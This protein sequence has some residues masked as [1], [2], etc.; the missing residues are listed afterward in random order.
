MLQELAS[1]LAIPG[2]PDWMGLVVLAALALAGLAYLLMPFSVF[3]VKGR[4]DAIE[5]RGLEIDGLDILREDDVLVLQSKQAQRSVLADH[6][7]SASPEHHGQRVVEGQRLMQTVSDPFL[8]WTTNAHHEHIYWRH[9]R[10]WKGAVQLERLDPHALD[11][12]GRLCAITLAKAHARSGDRAAITDCM[13]EG[14]R[15]DEA[16]A[17]FAMAYADQSAADDQRLHAAIARGRLAIADG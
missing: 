11:L 17:A 1:Q 14:K 7:T 6:A 16:I 4:L 10:D 15:F 13:A 9:F 2:L 5:A 3:G 8:G 12:Y